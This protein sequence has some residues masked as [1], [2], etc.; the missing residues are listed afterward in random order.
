M[1]DYE[2]C[3]ERGD[4]WPVDTRCSLQAGHHPNLTPSGPH[5]PSPVLLQPR[6]VYFP[7]AAT[8]E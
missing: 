4:G 1:S 6:N 5:N 2:P 3:P 8:K 7:K